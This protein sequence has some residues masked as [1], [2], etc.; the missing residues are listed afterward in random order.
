LNERSI[1]DRLISLGTI[2]AHLRIMQKPR[3][4]SASRQR[5]LDL[6]KRTFEFAKRVVALSSSP[7]TTDAGRII[8]R[9]LIRSATSSSAN[10]EEADEA[11]SDGDFVHK[12][13]LTAR[14]MKESRRWLRFIAAC[15]LTNHSRLENL[16]DE[17]RQLAAIFATIVVNTKERLE[18]EKAQKQS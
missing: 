10:L 4:P 16:E 15:R 5:T 3:Q 13:K 12:M 6:Q 18:R 17:A 9:Q 14:E 8:W 7:Q 2:A 1:N 11:S